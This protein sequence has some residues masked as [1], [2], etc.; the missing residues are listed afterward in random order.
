MMETLENHVSYLS[1]YA[2][3]MFQESEDIREALARTYGDLLDFFAQARRV[4]T[5]SEGNATRWTSFKVFFRMT[6]QPFEENFSGIKAKFLANAEIVTREAQVHGLVSADAERQR[7][8]MREQQV[9]Q[10]KEDEKRREVFTW[11]SDLDF[12]EVHETQFLKRFGE[13]GNWLLKD[14]GFTD[15]QNS[16]DSGLLWIHGTPGTGKTVLCSLVLETLT[17]VTALSSPGTTGIAFAYCNYSLPSTQQNPGAFIATF[18]KQLSRCCPRIPQPLEKL[19]DSHDKNARNPSYLELRQLFLEVAAGFERIYV[20][21]DAL[22]EFDPQQR[23]SFLLFLCEIMKFSGGCIKLFITSRREADIERAFTDVPTIAIESAMLKGDLEEYV[24]GE[25]ERRYEEGALRLKDHTLKDL[26]FST[27]IEKADGMFL[28][29]KFQLDLLC[30]QTSDRHIRKALQN[31]PATMDETYTRCLASIEK[32]SKSEIEL[33]KKIFMW[34]TYAQRPMRLGELSQAVAMELDMETPEDIEDSIVNDLELLVTVCGG[35]VTVDIM[36]RMYTHSTVRF[37]HFTVQ[38]FL[39]GQKSGSS[40]ILKQNSQLAHEEIAQMS[41]KYLM[42][43]YSA[44]SEDIT[45]W[46]NFDTYATNFWHYHIRVL[47]QLSEDVWVLLYSFLCSGELFYRTIPQFQMLSDDTSR[48]IS[49]STIAAVLDLP[50]ALSRLMQENLDKSDPTENGL[51]AIHW[52]AEIGSFKGIEWLLERGVDVNGM[53]A[54]GSTALYCAVLKQNKDLVE[55]LISKGADVNAKG[56]NMGSSLQAAAKKGDKELI[57][58][59]LE[60]G[61]DI[62]LRYGEKADALQ[63]VAALGNEE[64]VHLLLENGANINAQCGEHGSVLQAAFTSGNEQLVR[65]LL[66]KGAEATIQGKTVAATALSG[67]IALIELLLEM[68]CDVNSKGGRQ[69]SVLKSAIWSGNKKL[70]EFLIKKG[71]KVNMPEVEDG[72]YGSALNAAALKGNEEIIQLLLT[73]GA[74]VNKRCGHFGNPL[75]AAVWSGN[76][77]AIKLLLDN[78]ADPNSRMK[79]GANALQ[80]VASKG[81][82]Q[83][84]KLLLENGADPNLK[85]GPWKC[86]M[87]AAR[88]KNHE[89]VTKVLREHGGVDYVAERD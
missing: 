69:G 15:W 70:V 16:S 86:A 22:D 1:K 49:P 44:P 62:N 37:V 61:A 18:I 85:G 53:S 87:E 24:E 45:P 23:G 8:R 76:P 54:Y 77:V 75:H 73:S 36:H 27:L 55:F 29:V 26:I 12:E 56:G 34:L 10:E 80:V 13:T 28:W 5:D 40:A 83:L 2:M 78:G 72:Y 4:F 33:A 51:E 42:I 89:R 19:F 43:M 9:D 58:L 6:W 7:I 41:I 14:T 38:E 35:L 57:Q 48:R 68:G 30:S 79:D 64:L 66:T 20:V 59:L 17:E 52:A 63:R 67:N 82:L 60:H 47:N 32:K 21:I 50:L 84:V 65:Y 3:S 25:L 11:L 88:I 31:L 81:Q 71:A 74:E 39:V 46:D